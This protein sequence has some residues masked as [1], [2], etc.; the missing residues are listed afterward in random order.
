M[1]RWILRLK[2]RGDEGLAMLT[3]LFV[4]VLITGIGAVVVGIS[5][6]NLEDSGQDRLAG[7]A[8]GATEAGVA[9]GET[10]LRTGGRALVD[11]CVAAACTTLDW[12]QVGT[13]HQVTPPGAPTGQYFRVWIQVVQAF[14]PPSQP[15]GVYDI[16]S[17]GYA[18]PGPGE[19][20]VVQ[21][22]SL[23]PYEFPVGV[24]AN[25]INAVGSAGV[26]HESFF[27]SHDVQG[28]SHM[29]FSPVDGIDPF[30]GVYAGVS[31]V[32]SVGDAPNSSTPSIHAGGACN[33]SYPH[34]RDSGGSAFTYP[35]VCAI[36]PGGTAETSKFTAADLAATYGLQA[37]GLSNDEYDA[38]KAQAM[39]DGQY[40]GPSDTPFS[41]PFTAGGALIHNNVVVYI[42]GQDVQLGND[43]N[44][45][46][47]A[48]C[49]SVSVVLIVRGG[50]LHVNAGADFTGAM[51][52]PDGTYFGNGHANIYG[53]LWAQTINKFN[54]TADF[55]LLPCWVANM[56]GSLMT[57]TP[58]SYNE[59]YGGPTP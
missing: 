26:H 22:V 44:A 6:K 4:M 47:T 57:L 9:A 27:T 28:R 5:T 23:K 25:Y 45:Y 16:H 12:A 29:T 35:T 39:S 31:A 17:R 52:V 18:G 13:G 59:V 37:N 42:D 43:L 8:L 41:H 49:G 3:T 54:G 34:D 53:T 30:Y 48:Q 46:S 7:Q 21:R 20:E 58:E 56:P 40:Y 14:S 10:Y 36:K 15:V 33:P 32:G 1:T 38:L 2:A 50:N 51:F 24:F 55:S 11:S 19:H